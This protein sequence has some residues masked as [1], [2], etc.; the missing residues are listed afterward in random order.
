[1]AG[2]SQRRS[3]WTSLQ[4]RCYRSRHWSTSPS[5]ERLCLYWGDSSHNIRVFTAI[6]SPATQSTIKGVR[7]TSNARSFSLH[8]SVYTS[9]QDRLLTQDKF[10]QVWVTPAQLGISSTINLSLTSTSNSICISTT[11]E[12]PISKGLI[13][14]CTG[15]IQLH[16]DRLHQENLS[17]L[18]T[19]STQHQ[20]I[21]EIPWLHMHNHAQHPCPKSCG[22]LWIPGSIHQSQW[23][24]SLSRIQPHHQPTPQHYSKCCKIYP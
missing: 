7:P 22:I 1:M 20:V 11:D 14:Q 23:F 18:V 5:L 13:R 4:K 2:T 3:H 10:L 19:N 21:L 15:P 17:L 8:S 24:T 6:E 12:G 9:D 16:S